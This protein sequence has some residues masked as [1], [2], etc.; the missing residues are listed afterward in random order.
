MLHLYRA[1]S[2]LILSMRPSEPPFFHNPVGYYPCKKCN[3]CK[4]NTQGRC[5]TQQFKSTVTDRW[6]CMKHF[7]TCATKNVAYLLTC[8]CGKTYV[9]RII[10][11]FSVRV[12]EPNLKVEIPNA[13]YPNTIGSTTD[14][15]RIFWIY[16][17]TYFSPCGL[18]TCFS[19]L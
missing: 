9:G 6:Y 18:C 7:G 13:L 19:Q 10:R 1:R 16:H 11:P 15:I 12:T 17:N 3:V 4:Y 5:K 14:A 8:P 2:L